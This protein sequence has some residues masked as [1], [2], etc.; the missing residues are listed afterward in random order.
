MTSAERSPHELA[1]HSESDFDSS[2]IAETKRERGIS[3]VKL[4]PAGI[5]LALLVSAPAFAQDSQLRYEVT[6][7][8]GY[9][10]G[11][12]FDDETG[13]RDFE[14]QDSDALGLIINGR[15]EENTQWEFLL[16]R[17]STSVDTQGLFVDDPL[18]DINVDYFHL[19]GTY[20]F[21]GDSVRPFVALT[22]GATRFNPDPSGFGSETYFSAAFGGGWQFNAS[23]RFGVRLEAR[24]FTT[25]LDNDSSLFCQSD[26]GGAECLIA[27]ESNTLTQWEARAG[28]VFRF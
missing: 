2:A 14:L 8:I 23:K 17:Q 12:S 5:L 10:M 28:L 7:Y 9:R 20:L 15:V 26:A 4:A 3:N 27:V 13:Q 1:T 22:L 18:L 24:A 25:F 16:G 21:D 6:P 11:G 19:G